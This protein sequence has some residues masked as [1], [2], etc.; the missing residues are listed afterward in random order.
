MSKELEEAINEFKRE[1]EDSKHC[2]ADL[3]ISLETAKTILNYIDNSVSKEEIQELIKEMHQDGSY[4]WAN[5]IEEM[6]AG[7]GISTKENTTNTAGFVNLESGQFWIH[8]KKET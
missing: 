1:Y 5:R 4:Y 7:N 2:N 8:D 6:I 3:I